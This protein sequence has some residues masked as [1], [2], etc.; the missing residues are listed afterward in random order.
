MH[1]ETVYVCCVSVTPVALGEQLHSIAL[2][3]AILPTSFVSSSIT[4]HRTQVSG[5]ASKAV[6]VVNF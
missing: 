3:F 6:D 4:L 1:G 5:T 2:H